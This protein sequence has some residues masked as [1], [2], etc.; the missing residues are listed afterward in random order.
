MSPADLES[1][2]TR[3]EAL[4][5][6]VWLRLLICV[7]LIER[8]IGRRLRSRF[9][10]ST[11]RFEVLAQLWREQGGLAMSELSD[12]MMVTKG[13]VSGLIGRIERD[14]LIER[15]ADPSDRRSQI[16]RLTARGRERFD[17]M[18]A[19]HHRWLHELMRGLDGRSRRSLH[20]LLDALR[21]SIHSHRGRASPR[22][23][24]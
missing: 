21:A 3:D 19:S 8:E 1:S 10:T 12:R 5:V 17:A 22:R 6:R 4:E 13:N 18:R 20:E 7:S 23:G 11:A 24:N 14:G 15:H 9:G 2:V 16:V